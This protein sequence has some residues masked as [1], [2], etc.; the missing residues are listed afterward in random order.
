M[1]NILLL[2]VSILYF[3]SA[4]ASKA[5]ITNEKDNTLSVIDIDK[6]KVI[7]SIPVGRYPWGV[8]VKD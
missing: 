5:Y 8:A 3:S 1:F 7:K 2:F 4:D 6:R